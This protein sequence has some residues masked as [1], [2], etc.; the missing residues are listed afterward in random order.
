[1]AEEFELNLDSQNQDGEIDFSNPEA[2]K[3]AYEKAL[4][5][6]KQLFARAKKAEGFE[7]KDG[8]W[9]RG[10]KPA[11]ETKPKDE[12]KLSTDYGLL[13]FLKVNNIEHE[14]DVAYFN[15]VRSET[16]KKPEE[17][18]RS[19]Y[20]QAELKERQEIRATKEALPKENNRGGSKGGS[21]AALWVEKVNS[22]K[23]TMADVPSELMTEVIALRV[24]ASTVA[25]P[26]AS[27]LDRINQNKSK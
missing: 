8:Q 22:G 5:Q 10:S 27:V 9:V 13:A 17:I 20:F 6:N 11:P 4:S 25:S 26:A 3:E 12:P 19:K 24:K 1:M 14:D 18:I 7:L 15:Q 21:E 23:A 2:A 16:G